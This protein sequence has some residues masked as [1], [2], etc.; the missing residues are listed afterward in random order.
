MNTTPS[1]EVADIR[2]ELDGAARQAL[3]QGNTRLATILA[4]VVTPPAT[5][6][7]YDQNFALLTFLRQGQLAEA[8]EL[9]RSIVSPDSKNGGDHYIIG[10]KYLLFGH[11]AQAEHFLRRAVELGPDFIPARE[12]LS[13]VLEDQDPSGRAADLESKTTPGM[14][15]S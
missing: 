9:V 14:T 13:R 7:S 6:I 2:A 11:T 10:T 1:R 12:I 4:G 3:A 15:P 8:E 5:A